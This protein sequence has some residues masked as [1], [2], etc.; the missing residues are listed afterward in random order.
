MSKKKAPEDLLPNG[1][2]TKY[3]PEYD[4]QVVKLCKLGATD[5]EIAD[6]FE[7]CEATLNNWKLSE[8]TFLE[9]IRKGKIV[10][11]MQVVNALHKKACGYDQKVDKIFQF[12]GEPVIVPTIEHIAPD[13]A[14]AFIW[15]KNRRKVD[16]KDK[17]E[18]EIS[19][20]KPFEINI[21]VVD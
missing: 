5:K 16:W 7:V 9:S 10:A 2:P 12:Q 17:Q 13:T 8:P 3:L 15:L 14:A 1:R 11:D 20:E 21:K 6:F 4:K 18:I 19:Q